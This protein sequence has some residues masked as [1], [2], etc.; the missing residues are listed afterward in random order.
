M[1]NWWDQEESKNWK[2]S[3]KNTKKAKNIGCKGV[4]LH[5]GSLWVEGSPNIGQNPTF[6]FCFLRLPYVSCVFMYFSNTMNKLTTFWK[7]ATFSVAGCSFTWMDIKEVTATKH[8]QHN[9]HHKYFFLS[10]WHES[11]FWWKLLVFHQN[12]A[13]CKYH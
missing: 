6:S 9:L 1:Q 10:T 3:K 13:I 12:E 8:G 5:I 7:W 2:P 4:R 11:F